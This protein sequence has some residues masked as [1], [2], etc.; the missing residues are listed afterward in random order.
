MVDQAEYALPSDVYRILKLTVDGY[1][2]RLIDWETAQELTTRDL[3]RTKRWTYYLGFDATNVE[4]VNLY[5]APTTAGLSIQAY[6]VETPANFADDS[7]NPVVPEQFHRALV[8]YASAQAFVTIEDNPDLHQ[9]HSAAYDNHLS[10]ARA[11]R[12]SRGAR[13]PAS[14]KIVG[15]HK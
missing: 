12:N 5:P 15:I 6:V 11:L 7:A 4:T 1:T 10:E 9:Y 2:A 14:I 8:H 13:G 3:W